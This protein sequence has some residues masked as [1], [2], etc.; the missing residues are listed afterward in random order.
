MCDIYL[1]RYWLQA[2]RHNPHL[3][4]S[5]AKRTPDPVK[6]LLKRA[7]D[8]ALGRARARPP[9]DSDDWNNSVQGAWW[10]Q[11]RP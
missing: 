9:V 1:A 3:Q 7:K 5:N 10:S 2:I 6:I 11:S 4:T 8:A